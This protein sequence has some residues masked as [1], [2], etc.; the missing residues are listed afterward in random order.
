VL[1]ASVTGWACLAG[2]AGKAYVYVVYTCAESRLRP[3][4]EGERREWARL[5]DIRGNPLNAGFSHDGPHTPELMKRLGL[6]RYVHDGV[7]LKDIDN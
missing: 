6:G 7:Q 1:D 4:C 3:E 5:F 2:T